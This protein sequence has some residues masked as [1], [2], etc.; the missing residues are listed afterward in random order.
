MNGVLIDDIPQFLAPVPC[1]TTNV[2][3]IMNPFN[4]THS[5]I[6]T[7]KPTRVT[8]YFDVRKSI[9]EVYAEDRTH[10]IS[11]NMGSVKP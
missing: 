7:L 9:Q 10:S 2:K 4:A 6:I 8:S 11:S 1:V 5:I 3:Q